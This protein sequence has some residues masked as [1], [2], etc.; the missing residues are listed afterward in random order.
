MGGPAG[1]KSFARATSQFVLI[2][3]GS[4]RTSPVDL[5]QRQRVPVSKIC[6]FRFYCRNRFN[7]ARRQIQARRSS[8]FF[9]IQGLVSPS[10]QRLSGITVLIIGASC[11]VTD[12]DLFAM[13]L[14]F[15]SS[16]AGQNDVDFVSRALRQDYQ[17]F[18]AADADWHVTRANRPPHPPRK[19]FQSQVARSMSKFVVNFLEIVEI[20]D[21]D[22]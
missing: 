19:L 17:E 6:V 18:I 5:I 21:N 8:C 4:P 7:G 10:E 9:C 1:C 3:T 2:A 14:N 13:E 15:E 20:E 12:G 22:G 11:R 16:Y